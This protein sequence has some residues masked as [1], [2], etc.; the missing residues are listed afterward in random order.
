M[1]AEEQ[2]LRQI[3]SGHNQRDADERACNHV[4][5]IMHARN[6]PR[7]PEEHGEDRCDGARDR[8]QPEKDG[9]DGKG[10]ESMP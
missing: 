1:D 7:G 5:R 10:A 9:G 8:I 6:D 2:Q 3:Q 4:G